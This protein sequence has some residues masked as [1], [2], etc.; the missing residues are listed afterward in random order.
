[1]FHSNISSIFKKITSGSLLALMALGYWTVKTEKAFANS[2]DVT[3]ELMLSIDVSG[4]VDSDEY[5]LQMDGYAAAFRDNE[6]I[7]IIESLPDGL[8]VGVQFWA[9]YPAPSE[10]W[11]VIKTAEQSRAFANY[12]D[13]LARPSSDTTSVYT[14]TEN[15]IVYNLGI[16]GSTNI[17]GAIAAAADSIVSN[18]YN[19]NVLVIDISGD[20]R[21]NGY[22]LNGNTSYDG[23]CGGGSGNSNCPGVQNARDAAVALGITVNGLPIEANDTS[24]TMT[25]YYNNHVKGGARGFVE[26]ARG[27]SDFTRAAKTKIRQ[28]ISAALSPHAQDDTITANEDTAATYNLITGDPN[29]S[30]AGQDTDPNGETLTIRQFVVG[31]SEYEFNSQNTSIEVIMPSN[32]ILTVSSDGNVTY[33]PNGQFESMDA[34]DSLL[35]PDEFVYTV[36]NSSGYTGSARATL[37]I[38]GVADNPVASDDQ[39]TTDEDTS[40]DINVLA[41]DQDPDTS[42]SD[43]RIT[44][45]NNIP[46]S[47]NNPI[48]L[49]SGDILTLNQD[50]TINYDPSR[51]STLNLLNDGDSGTVTFS[52]TVSDPSGNTDNANVTVTVSGIDDTFAD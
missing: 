29:N 24:S 36:Q 47:V 34:S 27:F 14:W 16:G 3:A 12:L 6:V 39:G 41:N 40:E 13:S 15:Q 42:S 45:I 25:N 4:S 1:M 33:N 48:T 23:H 20:G 49:P 7:S 26:T 17:T 50:K 8:A 31:T 11:Q 52:Y 38:N 9:S 19:G 44:H 37:D 10:P 32:A 18:D 28:E 43:L 21:S 2:V 35:T 30:N 51:N 22:Q 5:N 46:V